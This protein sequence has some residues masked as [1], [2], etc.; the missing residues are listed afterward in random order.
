MFSLSSHVCGVR[1]E[2]ES[3]LLLNA[4]PRDPQVKA[5][6]GIVTDAAAYD[7]LLDG[8]HIMAMGIEG[9]GER[10]GKKTL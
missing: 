1:Y 2:P 10:G 4:I 5:A 8:P 9:E 7:K 6:A 3:A